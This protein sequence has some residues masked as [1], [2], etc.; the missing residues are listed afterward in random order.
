MSNDTFVAILLLL[1]SNLLTFWRC[2][3]LSRR[4]DTVH[5][6]ITL[7]N[8]MNGLKSGGWDADEPGTDVSTEQGGE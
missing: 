4:I 7:N 1:S 3:I 6:R 5:K 8:R 2:N